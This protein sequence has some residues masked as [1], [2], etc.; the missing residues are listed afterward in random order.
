MEYRDRGFDI[1]CV[2]LALARLAELE[3]ELRQLELDYLRCTGKTMNGTEPVLDVSF[4]T[5]RFSGR[6]TVTVSLKGTVLYKNIFPSK[7]EYTR[8]W[9]GLRKRHRELQE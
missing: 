5:S 9:V 6:Y 3:A 7:K 8:H 1:F 2:H 4:I